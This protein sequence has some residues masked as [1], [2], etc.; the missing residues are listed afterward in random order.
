MP[1]LDDMSGALVWFCDRKNLE[2]ANL[3][4][5]TEY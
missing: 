4:G 5:D 3:Q 1:I 2:N